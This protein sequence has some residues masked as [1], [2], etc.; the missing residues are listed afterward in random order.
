M[1]YQGSKCREKREP[2]TECWNTPRLSGCKK[3]KE[4]NQQQRL[5]Q[6]NQ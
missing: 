5:R 2:W 1:A 3:R 6:W 4:K